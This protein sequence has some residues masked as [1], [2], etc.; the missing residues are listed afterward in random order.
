MWPTNYAMSCQEGTFIKCFLMCICI[1]VLV[2][3]VP[4]TSQISECYRHTGLKC[5]HQLLFPTRMEKRINTKTKQLE[6]ITSTCFQSKQ[7]SILLASRIS[8]KNILFLSKLLLPTK[9]SNPWYRIDA[10]HH[11]CWQEILLAGLN[12]WSYSHHIHELS[13]AR[14]TV[15]K[16][17]N[18][19]DGDF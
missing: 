11:H 6:N 10:W 19:S 8:I 5:P 13:L 18:G 4:S 17:H 1:E 16:A 7:W 15:E 12:F 3:V 2:P 9:L 14:N